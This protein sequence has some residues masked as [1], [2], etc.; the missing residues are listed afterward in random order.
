MVEATVTVAVWG[1]LSADRVQNTE[2]TSEH[3]TALGPQ[4][5]LPAKESP[6]VHW[7]AMTVWPLQAS[8]MDAAYSQSWS[9]E[10]MNM[11][12]VFAGA[13]P[14]CLGWSTGY[15]LEPYSTPTP[16]ALTPGLTKSLN[17]TPAPPIAKDIF[18]S[19]MV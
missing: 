1:V 15:E 3:T 4:V 10:S 2:N 17:P 14:F 13:V 5:W 7:S 11:L 19:L 8:M 6:D 12:T 18:P 16:R 9:K